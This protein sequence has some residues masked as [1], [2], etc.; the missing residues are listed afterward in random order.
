MRPLLQSGQYD[1]S[2]TIEEVLYNIASG[3]YSLHQTH[4][5]YC[6]LIR[7]QLLEP[8]LGGS[9]IQFIMYYVC[10]QK[11]FGAP[12]QFRTED[13]FQK[14]ITASIART[15]R[16]SLGPSSSYSA[17]T[18]RLHPPLRNWTWTLKWDLLHRPAWVPNIKCV[19]CIL[20]WTSV[21][22]ISLIKKTCCISIAMLLASTHHV[23]L[24]YLCYSS[25]VCKL[26]HRIWSLSY[27]HYFLQTE[28]HVN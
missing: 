13:F 28:P 22:I 3:S 18:I 1:W 8:E 21:A 6:S 27:P 19:V 7:K 23:H 24:L 10:Q 2:P 20:W 15:L 4:N 11:N 17:L 9:G 12:L 5:R 25:K 14:F 26:D 16:L